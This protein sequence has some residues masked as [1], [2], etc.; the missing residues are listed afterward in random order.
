MIKTGKSR[1]AYD[2]KTP[3]GLGA[4][5]TKDIGAAATVL[6]ADIFALYLKTKNSHWHMS[7]RIS[8][9]ITGC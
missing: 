9:T 3:T 5:A 6:L 4:D 2:L 8:V 7:G 1:I